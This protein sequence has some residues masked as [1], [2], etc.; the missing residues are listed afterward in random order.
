MNRFRQLETLQAATRGRIPGVAVSWLAAARAPLEKLTTA[1][2]DP[3]ITDAEFLALVKSFSESLPS[4]LD[5]MD[6]ESLAS[7]MEESMGAAMANGISQRQAD[8]P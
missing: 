7:L 2:L 4:L 5:T 6:H 3:A 8:M 1:A